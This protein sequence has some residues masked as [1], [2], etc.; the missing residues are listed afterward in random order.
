[1]RISFIGTQ[2]V[3]KSSV[4]QEFIKKYPMFKLPEKSYRDV[5]KEQNLDINENGTLESQKIIRDVLV[6]MAL[7]NAGKTHT[8]HDRT[9]LD[10]LAYTLWLGEYDKLEGTDD[11]I[12]DFIATTILLVKESMK[13][14]DIIFWIPINPNI[15]LVAKENRSLNLE[16]RQEIDNIFDGFYEHYKSNSGLLFDKED[17]PCVIKLEGELQQRMDTIAMYIADDGGLVETERSAIADLETAWEE[18]Q[19]RRQVR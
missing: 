11:E 12:S 3:G 16:Y 6:D 10:N 9:V 8:V 7:E 13:F 14:Y 18:E 15:P 19:L 17:Q 1:M 5:I 2:N 4:I